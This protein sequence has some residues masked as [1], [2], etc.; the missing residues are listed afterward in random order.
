MDH[1]MGS[2]IHFNNMIG[3]W[4]ITCLVRHT[5]GTGQNYGPSPRSYDTLYKQDRTK[6]HKLGSEKH[7]GAAQR[8]GPSPWQFDQLQKQE[9]L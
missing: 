1:H 4:I 2:D 8:Y 5:L 7:T 3:I 9:K 6:E